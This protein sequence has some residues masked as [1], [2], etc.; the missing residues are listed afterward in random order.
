MESPRW[1]R[2]LAGPVAPEREDPTLEQSVPEGLHPMEVRGG[3]F[4]LGTL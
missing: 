3:L 2:L 4:L 1:S